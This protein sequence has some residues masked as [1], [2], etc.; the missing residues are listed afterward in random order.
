M[1]V[2]IIATLAR[3]IDGEY[4]FLKIDK[5]FTSA[6]AAESFYNS[7]KLQFTELIPTQNGD[8]NCLCQ[9]G[10]FEVDIQE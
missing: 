10:I 6:N 3:E 7:T 9:R 1:K 5:G 4:C 8:I 2:F